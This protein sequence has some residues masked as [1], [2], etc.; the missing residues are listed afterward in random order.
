MA[1]FYKNKT[2]MKSVAFF[3]ILVLSSYGQFL[4]G[5]SLKIDFGTILPASN[6]NVINSSV[7]NIANL[8]EF[9]DG[10]NSGVSVAVTSTNPFNNTNN[11]S[12]TSGLAELEVNDGDV[13]SDGFISQNGGQITITFTGLDDSLAYDI[14]AGLSRSSQPQNFSTTWTVNGVSQVSAGSAVAGHVEFEQLTSTGGELSFVLT[15]NG[16]HAGVAQLSLTA[17]SLV[18]IVLPENLISIDFGSTV[19]AGNHNVISSSMLNIPNL[20]KYSDGSDSN[21][22]LN[23]TATNLVNNSDN[24]PSTSGILELNV[25]SLAVYGD[26]VVSNNGGEIV[27][28]F[29][30]LDDNLYYDVTGGLSRPNDQQSFSTTWEVEGAITKASIGTPAN[31]HVSF[32][33]LSSTNGI[34]SLTLSPNSTHAAIAQLS[35]T[36]TEITPTTLALDLPKIVDLTFD[37]TDLL[38]NLEN[39]GASYIIQQSNDLSF[40]NT[41]DH[42]VEG[43]DNKTLRIENDANFDPDNDGRS[44]FRASRKP[45]FII[46]FT[47][48]QGYQDLSCYGSPTISTPRIDSLAKE[49]IRFTDFY[50]QPVCGPSRDALLTGC[51]PLRTAHHPGSN[52]AD[53]TSPHPRLELSEITIAEILKDQG[54]ATMATGKWDLDGRFEFNSP[55]THGPTAQGFDSYT[56]TIEGNPNSTKNGT[57]AAI[58][59]IKDN[60]DQP[61][62]A[63]VAYNMPQIELATTPDFAGVS[64]EGIYADVLAELDYNVGRIID[65]LEEEGLEEITYVMFISDNGPWYL[66][67]ST[68]HINRYGGSAAAEAMGGSALPLRGDKTTSW[69]GGFR[70]PSIMWAPGR[71]PAGQVSDKVATTMDVMPT[72]AHL[73]GGEVPT[74]RVID[75]NNITEIIHGE[76]DPEGETEA[77]FYY[78][79]ETLHAVRSGKWKMHIPHARDTFWQRFYRT[80]DYINITQPL[81]YDLEADIGETTNVA[82]DHP[83]VVADLM[84]LIQEARTDIGDFNQI[85]QNAR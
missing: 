73:A 14:A 17:T 65:T 27:I 46:V 33:S 12:S 1:F 53:R 76:Q 24:I 7:L 38:L 35:I 69:E 5:D 23:V 18:P 19:P 13:Y 22:S 34:L 21:I 81:L 52:G 84:L 63:Y 36:P 32:K 72:I 77:F 11:I 61:F 20:V 26:G 57:D 50:A 55:A 60:A 80:G 68:S 74:D 59:F 42:T 45:N 10:S 40:F 6:Y 79:R 62:F 70:V 64:G 54:Y 2:F 58:S 82:D 47:D 4:E 9:D 31:G 75:G 51:Y 8:M 48:D 56:P 43:V 66:G 41:I 85:G 71:I 67:N 30:G 15:R 49:G 78:V 37:N 25:Q 3:H 29:S 39:A 16:S 83:D 44:F 28:T